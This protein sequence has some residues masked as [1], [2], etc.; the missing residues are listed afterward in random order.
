MLNDLTLQHDYAFL[1]T[2]NPDGSVLIRAKHWPTDP[3][4]LPYAK[5]TIILSNPP[6]MPPKYVIPYPYPH[7]KV[8]LLPTVYGS[9]ML[10]TPSL[11]SMFVICY[12]LFYYLCAVFCL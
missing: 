5:N 1:L 12:F 11:Y 6:P 10:G 9:R 4:W 8:N 3:E 7:A 2:K